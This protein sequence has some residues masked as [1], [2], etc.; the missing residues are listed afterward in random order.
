MCV[1]ILRLLRHSRG[2][3]VVGTGKQYFQHLCVMCLCVTRG[4]KSI[5]EFRIYIHPATL[6]SILLPWC[7]S[8][9]STKQVLAV[10]IYCGRY[11]QG[12]HSDG[13]HCLEFFGA[14]ER[15]SMWLHCLTPLCVLCHIL[16]ALAKCSS[17][18]VTHYNTAILP[19]YYT[20]TLL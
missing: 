10:Y 5:Y 12:I 6:V 20:T 11:M 7:H 18:I 16:P 9:E 19:H 13:Q 1:N 14:A 2:D 15:S 3:C 17:A 8:L 4:I